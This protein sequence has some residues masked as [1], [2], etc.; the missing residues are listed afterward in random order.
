MLPLLGRIT[1]PL[2]FITL[3][4]FIPC[5]YIPYTHTESETTI[6]SSLLDSPLIDASYS[7]IAYSFQ[8]RALHDRSERI[9]Q[10]CLLLTLPLEE[11]RRVIG[12]ASVLVQKDLEVLTAMDSLD[13]VQLYQA[14]CADHLT[15]LQQLCFRRLQESCGVTPASFSFFS[16]D[17]WL[18]K[19]SAI[20]R[21]PVSLRE[22]LLLLYGFHLHFPLLS[23]WLH[24]A[25]D[26]AESVVSNCRFF[27]SVDADSQIRALS[28]KTSPRQLC[29]LVRVSEL[30]EA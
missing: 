10:D 23:A 26:D 14:L 8:Q 5:I 15:T 3:H 25:C 1:V 12:Q 27:V 29:L 6:L 28:M 16:A 20:E 7:Q 11:H 2:T 17:W 19:L 30:R 18:R 13:V 22:G 24:G 21:A 9:L 4:P